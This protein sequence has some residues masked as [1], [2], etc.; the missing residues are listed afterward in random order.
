MIQSSWDG[1][2]S[3]FIPY[4]QQKTLCAHEHSPILV[5]EA[6][7]ANMLPAQATRAL[8]EALQE[9][10]P[11][12]QT[13]TH[14]AMAGIRFPGVWPPNNCG[15]NVTAV[16]AVMVGTNGGVEFRRGWTLVG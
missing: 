3:K 7:A 10:R 6:T 9:G 11:R 14:D 12:V 8:H 16:V 13:Q 2:S 5:V 4:L 15:G 1:K